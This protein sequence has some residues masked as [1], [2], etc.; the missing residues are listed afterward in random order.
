MADIINFHDNP[1]Q[2]IKK[3]LAKKEEEL[4][5]ANHELVFFKHIYSAT[6]SVTELLKLQVV[7]VRA[8]VMMLESHLKLVTENLANIQQKLDNVDKMKAQVRTDP[9]KNT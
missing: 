7:D 8:N 5:R 3:E 4:A 6:V 2:K 1:V 9:P